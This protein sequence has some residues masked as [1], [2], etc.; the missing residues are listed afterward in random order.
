[1]MYETANFRKEDYRKKGLIKRLPL[2]PA[3]LWDMGSNLYPCCLYFSEV[4]W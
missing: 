4:F 1:M 2:P 3:G